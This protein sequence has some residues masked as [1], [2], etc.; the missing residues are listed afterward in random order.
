[1][2]QN[3]STCISYIHVHVCVEHMYIATTLL[4][5]IQSLVLIHSTF[6]SRAMM[7]DVMK[8]KMNCL[9]NQV[10]HSTHS[11][12][13][14]IN[15]DSLIRVSFSSTSSCGGDG[16]SHPNFYYI[17]SFYIRVCIHFQCTVDG[18]LKLASFQGSPSSVYI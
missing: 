12:R 14:I 11:W 4:V 9:M 16:E 2:H 7:N 1:M 8:R 15:M 17:A 5:V 10:V 13:P 18:R 6:S 3:T